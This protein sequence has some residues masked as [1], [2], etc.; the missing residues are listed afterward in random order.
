M[1]G[2]DQRQ[3]NFILSTQF[4]LVCAVAM[5]LYVFGWSTHWTF[6]PAT[7]SPFLRNRFF[8]AQAQSLLNG[9]LWVDRQA[10]PWECFFRDGKCYGYFGIMPSL[11]RVPLLAVFGSHVKE[12]AALFISVACGIATWA[13]VDMCRTL[14]LASGKVHDKWADWS[15]VSAALL[16]GPAG[17]LLLLMDP[18][19]Y[20]ESLAWSVAGVLVAVNLLLRWWQSRSANLLLYATAALVFASGARLTAAFAGTVAAA[21]LWYLTRDGHLD[22]RRTRRGLWALALVPILTTFSVMFLKFGA[23]LPPF[24]SYQ[25]RET[26]DIQYVEKINPGLENGLRNLPTSLFGYVRP[27]AVR[28]QSS[29]PFVAFRF[30]NPRWGLPLNRIT[31]LPPL[32][33]DSLYVE[34]TSSLTSLA[35]AGL[36]AIVGATYVSYRKRRHWVRLVLL[37]AVSVQP[38]LMLLSYGI[39]VRYMVDLYPLTVIA[40]ALLVPWMAGLGSASR[41][42]KLLAGPIIAAS[43]CWSLW[44]IPVLAKQDARI[45]MFGIK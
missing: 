17:L 22:D 30:G 9:H 6:D 43:I 25:S 16:I 4:A 19:V 3:S 20:Q 8:T 5:A 24:S 36:A 44:V 12:Y 23:P 42:M 34:R 1:R 37:A 38:L 7:T 14:L 29:Y 32:Q 21:G 26:A 2:T 18:Y 41:R 11:L 31:Y 33:K 45:Y 40:T 27:D 13:G 15:M 35:P 10:H 39:A 28:I